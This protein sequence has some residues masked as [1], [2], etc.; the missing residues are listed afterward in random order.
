MIL[1]VSMPISL[2]G[3][4]KCMVSDWPLGAVSEFPAAFFPR[5]EEYGD[6]FKEFCLVEVSQDAKSGC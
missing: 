2:E 6:G 4:F 5:H 1:V 3:L